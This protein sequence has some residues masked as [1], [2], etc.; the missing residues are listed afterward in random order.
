V[1]A[2]IKAM[3]SG[4]GPLGANGPGAEPQQPGGPPMYTGME[5]LK[6]VDQKSNMG[7]ARD[8]SWATL[9]GD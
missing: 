8:H 6:A 4:P 7:C 5:K 2:M 3:E 1:I 9:G